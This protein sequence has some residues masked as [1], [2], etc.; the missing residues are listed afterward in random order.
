M[1]LLVFIYG[2]IGLGAA[3]EVWQM[4]ARERWWARPLLVAAGLLIGIVW[5]LLIGMML[6]I[7]AGAR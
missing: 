5:P 7:K 1:N 6:A 2:L 3:I 4:D